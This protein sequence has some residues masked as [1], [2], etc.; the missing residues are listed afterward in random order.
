MSFF[1]DGLRPVGTLAAGPDGAFYGATVIGGS[2]YQG[3]VFRITTNGTMTWST[4]F[5][6]ANGALPQEGLVFGPD[7][8]LYGTTG[9]GGSQD[10]GT[11]FRVTTNGVLT[12][13]VSFDAAANKGMYPRAPLTLGR[14]GA[15]Y[16]T[17]YETSTGNNGF[18]TVFRVTTS[19]VFSNLSTFADYPAPSYPTGPLTLGSDGA[20]YGSTISGGKWGEGT[21]YRITTNGIRTTLVTFDGT[22]GSGPKSGV[23]QARNGDFYGTTASG[24]KFNG[25]NIFRVSLISRMLPLTRA[26]NGWTVKFSGVAGNTN[27]LLRATS[28]PGIWVPRSTVVVGSDGTG[29]FLDTTAPAGAAFY[30]TIYP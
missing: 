27:R 11:I 20:F 8:A 6:G 21:L 3:T 18:G 12:L 1:F 28:L 30:R 22:T 5:N 25:G 26:V 16:G 2:F 19:G 24:G 29:Q 14:D 9:L 15:L 17:T 4:S 7:G 10:A 23:I 13:L